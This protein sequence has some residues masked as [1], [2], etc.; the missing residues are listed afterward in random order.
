[1]NNII[2]LQYADGVHWY[3]DNKEIAIID[4]NNEIEWLIKKNRL[5]KDVI[6]AIKS[7]RNKPIGKFEFTVQRVRGSVTQGSVRVCLNGEEMITFNDPYKLVDGEWRSSY[8][9]DE[10]GKVLYSLLYHNYDSIYHYSDR[11]KNVLKPNWNK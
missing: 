10:L 5:S 8:A 3:V 1:M 6:D 7:K 11:V 4:E 9:D 2:G